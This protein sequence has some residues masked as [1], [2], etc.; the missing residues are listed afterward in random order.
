M[1]KMLKVDKQLV[2]DFSQAESLVVRRDRKGN[3]LMTLHFEDTIRGQKVKTTKD[4]AV[5][6]GFYPHRNRNVDT[7]E[8]YFESDP[9]DSYCV[10]HVSLYGDNHASLVLGLVKPGDEIKF[11]FDGNIGRSDLA[12]AGF[13]QDSLSLRIFRGTKYLGMVE[14]E[15][16]VNPGDCARMINK[17]SAY[18]DID[19]SS[20]NLHIQNKESLQV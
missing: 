5:D 14:L 2:K 19:Y 1:L 16:R 10:E 6:V 13:H 3:G 11:Q 12:K 20:Y 15:T 8:V 7:H 4:W 18:S 9:S 17:N